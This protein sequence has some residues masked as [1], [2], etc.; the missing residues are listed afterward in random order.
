MESLSL[1]K[2]IKD[3]RNLIMLK[4]RYKNTYTQKRN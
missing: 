2:E 3:I 1:E 4:N